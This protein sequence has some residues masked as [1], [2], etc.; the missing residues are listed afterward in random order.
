MLALYRLYGKEQAAGVWETCL[1]PG[2]PQLRSRL[3]FGPRSQASLQK[4]QGPGVCTGVGSLSLLQQIF[5]TQELNWGLL[6]WDAVHGVA[7]SRT[8]LSH[9]TFTFHFHALGKEMATHSSVLGLRPQGPCRVGGGAPR[10]S[11]G[12]GATEEGL[13]SRGGMLTNPPAMQETPVQF[14]GWEDPLERGYTPV[15]PPP[16][17]L[18]SL[19]LGGR[20]ADWPAAQENHE[21][22]EGDDRG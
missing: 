11:A 7:K 9:F 4:A 14:L 5:P 12:S 18:G 15:F 13:T 19:V 8:R 3:P 10:D 6:W 16:G 22:G 1:A 20:P 2:W 21:E 17:S